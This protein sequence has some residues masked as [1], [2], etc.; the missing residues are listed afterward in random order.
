MI[1]KLA[2]KNKMRIISKEWFK[3]SE[4]MFTIVE[5]L[6]VSAKGTVHCNVA[7][8]AVKLWLDK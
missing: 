1:I 4:Y 3:L 2:I 8:H 7:S 5:L 6:V